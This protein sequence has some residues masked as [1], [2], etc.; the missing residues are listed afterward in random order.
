MKKIFL[1]LA[2]TLLSIL[3]GNLHAMQ[4]FVKNISTG[5]MITL[6]LES[7]DDVENIKQQIQVIEGIL[8]ETQSLYFDGKKL[9]EGRTISDYNISKSSVLILVTPTKKSL[10][11]V[12][13]GSSFNVKAGTIV[14]ADKLELKP[15]SD[16]ALT[17]SLDISYGTTN[18]VK[19][20]SLTYFYT[21]YIFQT[22]PLPFSG[23]ITFGYNDYNLSISN[24]NNLKLLYNSGNTSPW[25]LDNSSSI[26]R[27]RS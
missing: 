20:N 22:T 9:E 5:K 12:A 16:Y 8:P 3:S 25:K 1:T 15:A 6:E 19:E 10:L 14:T 18:K 13:S 2:I 21:D 23:D 4:I 11:S 27:N 7:S 17:S 24:A 26:Y